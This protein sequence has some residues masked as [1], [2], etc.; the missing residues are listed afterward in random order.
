MKKGKLV[1]IVDDNMNFVKRLMSLLEDVE[2][3][4]GI[5]VATDFEEARTLF[6]AEPHQVVLLDIN[7]PGKNGIELLK[8][9]RQQRPECEVIMIT[10]HA[11]AYYR[12]QC[13]QLGAKH[14][15]DKSNDY[16]AISTLV[17]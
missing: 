10:N 16:G 6:M 9:F 1:L 11:D 12:Q 8:L 15:L 5:N 17:A 13:L 2:G 14:F 4:S 7:L 3:I